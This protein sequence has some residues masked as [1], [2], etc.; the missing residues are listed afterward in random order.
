MA[1]NGKVKA[2]IITKEEGTEV[3]VSYTCTAEQEMF[4]ILSMTEHLA[5]RMGL[6]LL[7]TSTRLVSAL[8]DKDNEH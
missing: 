6:S 8:M 4:L 3:K 5:E 2:T 1:T 7:D